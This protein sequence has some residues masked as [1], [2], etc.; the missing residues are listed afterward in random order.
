MLNQRN[1]FE[2][3]NAKSAPSVAA[4]PL[5]PKM[6]EK[7]FFKPVS[8][9]APAAKKR[10]SPVIVQQC[11]SPPQSPIV[12][13]S[14]LQKSESWHQMIMERMRQAKP[15]SPI[16][17]KMP[18]AKSTHNLG[19]MPKQYEAVL[20]PETISIKQHTVEQ[21]L[22]KTVQ[23]QETRSPQ[24]T[25]K[26]VVGSVKVAKLNEDFKHVDEA[27]DLLFNEAATGKI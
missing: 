2:S 15:P 6:N 27:F 22:G 3:M 19:N 16:Q 8:A 14:V 17:A 1:K 23:S 7:A 20:S 25:R 18:R 21:F 12:M 26:A 24:S 10:N 5:P 11:R 4:Q 13:P 9:G